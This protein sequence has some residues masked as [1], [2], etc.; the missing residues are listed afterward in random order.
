LLSQT[1]EVD[2][3]MTYEELGLFGRL[4]KIKMMGPV[5]MFEVKFSPLFSSLRSL[6][7][8]SLFLDC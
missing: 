3:G 8:I 6:K 5:S 7:V 2:M 1:D 4:R